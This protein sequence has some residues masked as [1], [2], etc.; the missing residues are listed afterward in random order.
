[1]F[2]SSV[3]IAGTLAISRAFVAALERFVTAHDIPL[4][5][6]HKQQREDDVMA[7]HL[8]GSHLPE[9]VL[10]L[11]KRRRTWAS[12]QS[13]SVCLQLDLCKK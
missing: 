4:V 9:G 7:K 3:S 2:S 1:L 8:R 11:G 5:V 10:F 6:F 12:I 13:A